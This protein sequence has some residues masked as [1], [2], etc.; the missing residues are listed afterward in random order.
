MQELY[1]D[2]FARYF[3]IPSVVLRYF[4][5]YGTKRHSERGSYPN[6]TAA[7]SRDKRAKNKAK[8]H[9]F[10]MLNIML[11]ILFFKKPKST[12]L[13]IKLINTCGQPVKTLSPQ[14]LWERVLA[15]LAPEVKKEDLELWLQ[16]VDGDPS[17]WPAP[18]IEFDRGDR[19][20]LSADAA[21][22]Q[23][24]LVGGKQEL[25]L[26]YLER[27]GFDVDH[28]FV[29]LGEAHGI[30]YIT[31]KKFD[32]FQTVEYAHELGEETGERPTVYYDREAKRILLVG[33]AYKIA[34]VDQ[35]LGA[36]PGIVN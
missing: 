26:D 17:R 4:G 23:L 7:F 6:V 8:K 10:F 16:P 18:D 32:D 30:S 20:K 9:T 27:Q 2:L 28:R 15:A 33:G 1:L 36:S 24:Y 19:V 21:G 35:E 5:I 31:E 22:K 11:R 34:P 12:R 14:E 3:N 25:P 29:S 13:P